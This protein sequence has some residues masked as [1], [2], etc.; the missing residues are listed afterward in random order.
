MTL[1]II[2]GDWHYSRIG[3]IGNV[4]DSIAEPR[5][6]RLQLFIMTYKNTNLFMKQITVFERYEF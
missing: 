6:K 1:A 4:V 3:V 5:K 2:I